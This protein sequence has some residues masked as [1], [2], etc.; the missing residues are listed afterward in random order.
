MTLFE[1]RNHVVLGLGLTVALFFAGACS[2]TS[3]MVDE[4]HPSSVMI[5]HVVVGHEVRSFQECGSEEV[6]WVVDDSKTVERL[7]EESTFG[8][9][10]YQP[11]FASVYAVAGP[12]SDD[13]FAADYDGTVLVD[14]INYW[15]IEGFDC[16]YSWNEFE[17]RAWSSEPFFMLSIKNDNVLVRDLVGGEQSWVVQNDGLKWS[18][19][20]GDLQVSLEGKECRDSMSGTYFGY[21][22]TFRI[23]DLELRGCA[24]SGIN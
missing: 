16:N 10:P 19:P 20:R 12:K 9:Q 18:S 1:G 4:E 3:E 11:A 22:A 2:D 6:Y 13:G 21:T 23:G 24:A 7:Y 15:P 14:S 8:M 5:G 17:Y